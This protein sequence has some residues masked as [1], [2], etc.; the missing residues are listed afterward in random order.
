MIRIIKRIKKEI[1]EM[2]FP[3]RLHGDLIL[4][5]IFNFLAKEMNATSIGL[6]R[7]G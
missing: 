3:V 6:I 2:L 4:R 5:E 7:L 1:E